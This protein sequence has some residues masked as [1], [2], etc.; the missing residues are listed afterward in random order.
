MGIR[1]LEKIKSRPQLVRLARALKR[2]GKRIVTTNGSFDLLHAGHAIAFEE[3]KRK[4]DVLM[5]LVNSDESV[6][7]YKGPHRPILPERER[8]AMVAAVGAVDYVTLFHELNPKAILAEIQPHVHCNAGE[9]GKNCVER[10]VVEAHGGKIHVLKD[11]WDG[12]ST[13]AILKKA[14]TTEAAHPVRAIFLDRDGT[15][16]DNGDG[17]IHTRKDFRFL[18]HVIPA[19]Q[20]LAQSD[21]K[22]IVVTNQSGIARGYYNEVTMHGLHRFMRGELARQKVHLHRIY[23]CPHGPSEGCLCRKPQP[24]MLLQAVKDFGI[25]LSHSWL[26]GDSENDVLAGREVNVKTIKLGARMPREKK[27]EPHHYAAHLGEA[28]DIILGES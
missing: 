24:G 25:S 19:L 3:A 12:M 5:V 15:L 1:S 18:P 26:V 7:S 2:E 22:L 21:Y 13:S 11:R 16:N 23:H 6:R 28:A 20:R 4:G 9:W 27:I 10:A 8:M 17:Y 14:I